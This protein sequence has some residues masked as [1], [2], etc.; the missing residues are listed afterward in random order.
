MNFHSE[1]FCTKKTEQYASLN[2][3]TTI[4]IPAVPKTAL[5]VVWN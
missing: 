1:Q 2:K 4:C 3:I 5:I